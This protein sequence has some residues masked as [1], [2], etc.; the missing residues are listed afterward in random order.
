MRKPVLNSFDVS[1]NVSI[2]LQ[3]FFY[4]LIQFQNN[5]ILLDKTQLIN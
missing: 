2:L 3:S 5:Q 4:K 1:E